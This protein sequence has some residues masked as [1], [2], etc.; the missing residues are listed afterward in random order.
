M[1]HRRS[2]EGSRRTTPLWVVAAGCV[3]QSLG[4]GL[5]HGFAV[6]VLS[7][8]AAPAAWA[9]PR[10]D[11]VVLLNGD[12]YTGEIKELVR[13]KLR[14]KTDTADTI[15]IQW[16]KVVSVQSQQ[17]LEVDLANGQRFHGSAAPGA[18][19]GLLQ[20]TDGAASTV[21]SVPLIQVV[22]IS[23]LDEGKRL[24]HRLDGYLTGGYSYTKANNLQVFSFTAGLSS[25]QEDHKWSV[26]GSTALTSQED[27][28]DTQRFDVTGQYRHFLQKRW[29][30]Q[31][32]LEFESNDELGLNLRTALGGAFGRYLVQSHNHEWAAYL[33]ANVTSEREVAAPDRENIEAV[34][35]TDFAVFKYDTPERTLNV[36]FSLLPSITDAG[37]VRAAAKLVSRYEIVKD[38]FFEISVYGTYD[39][40]PGVNAKSNSDYGTDLSLGY[41]F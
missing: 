16:D 11:V 23:P 8:L 26:D 25:T 3:R 14:L 6:L 10:T 32:T 35:G 30:W 22:Q 9:A 41:S 39:N 21:T 18:E 12:R 36:Q 2:D 29:F 27:S 34:L 1:K 13:G 31:S 38:F 20:L 24:L 4:L 15:Y 19:P 5:R 7:W 17:R 33:G 28:E 40:K 37:R